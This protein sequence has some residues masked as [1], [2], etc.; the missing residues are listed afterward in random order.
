MDAREAGGTQV[1]IGVLIVVLIGL[2]LGFLVLQGTFA[3]RAWRERI[4]AGDLDVLREALDDALEVWRE[5]RPPKGMPAADWAALASPELIAADRDRARV[6]LVADADVRVV[7]GERREIAG[8]LLVGRRVALRMAERLLYEIPHVRFAEVQIDVWERYRDAAGVTID[9][10]ILTTRATRE[11]AADVD[12]AVRW[13]LDPPPSP[14]A[15]SADAER[16][17]APGDAAAVAA[18]EARAR[19][20]DPAAVLARWRTHEASAT[21]A[22]G[23]ALD[24]DSDALILAGE[25]IDFGAAGEELDSG[26][27]AERQRPVAPAGGRGSAS[28]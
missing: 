14:A 22:L 3:A 17:D 20:L 13:E 25:G 11:E 15:S 12:W 7:A 24:S 16:S 8:P 18:A 23:G 5:M 10:A 1:E 21:A 6:S 27:A 28:Q 26:A 2:F 9:R 19:D 4:A